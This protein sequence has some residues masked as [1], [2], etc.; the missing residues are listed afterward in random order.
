MR[1]VDEAMRA[2]VGGGRDGLEKGGRAESV[3]NYVI[4]WLGVPR[5]ARVRMWEGRQR[6]GGTGRRAVVMLVGR[7]V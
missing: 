7:V 3:V 4:I 2:L 5:S 6:E 1:A